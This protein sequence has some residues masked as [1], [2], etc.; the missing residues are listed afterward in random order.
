MAS[1][2]HNEGYIVTICMFVFL[3]FVHCQNDENEDV[4]SLK[5]IR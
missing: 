4:Q 1:L 5:F 2:G 3:Y